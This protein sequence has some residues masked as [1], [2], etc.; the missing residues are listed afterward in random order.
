MIAYN[1]IRESRMKNV[2]S[3]N[4]KL[5]WRIDPDQRIPQLPKKETGPIV[6]GITIKEAAERKEEKPQKDNDA[7]CEPDEQWTDHADISPEKYSSNC[8]MSFLLQVE[9]LYYTE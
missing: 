2:F 5:P 7:K 6:Y 9:F 8:A 4:M 3:G 1:D